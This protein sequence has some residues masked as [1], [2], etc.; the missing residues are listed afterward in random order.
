MASVTSRL[1]LNDVHCV[2]AFKIETLAAY[3]EADILNF[4]VIHG[5]FFSYLAL[6][7]LTKN[8]PAVFTVRDMWPLTGHC[9]VS[10]DCERWKTGCGNCP[11]PSA[12]PALPT[13]RDSTHMEWKLKSWAYRQSRL[14]VVTLSR[15]MTEQARQSMLGHFPIHH[16]PNGVDTEA[17]RPLDP[18]LGRTVLGI[19]PGKKVLMF[20]AG[21][22]NR[23]HK[24]SDL[25][26][27]AL[28]VLPL[29]SSRKSSLSSSA[30]EAKRLRICLTYPLYPLDSL[31]D[32]ASRQL[33]ILRL[34]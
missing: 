25:L 34:T 15:R 3:R 14:T 18:A 23:Q 6:P 22:L 7:F 19:P 21:Y 4:H 10:Y 32:S 5:Q 1:G 30:R 13:K 8:K 27:K 17:Y 29:R 31:A 2:G 24:G 33:L 26:A 16:I 12:P 28:R 11:Y 9:A 20:A